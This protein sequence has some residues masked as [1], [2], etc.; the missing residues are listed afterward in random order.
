MQKSSKCPDKGQPA[1]PHPFF[2]KKNAGSLPLVLKID[3][4]Y[5]AAVQ[6]GLDLGCPRL[7]SWASLPPRHLQGG[8]GICLA[9]GCLPVR[10]ASFLMIDDL[11][12]QFYIC[13]R[14]LSGGLA[15]ARRACFCSSH[16]AQGDNWWPLEF[17]FHKIGQSSTRRPESQHTVYRRCR[18]RADWEVIYGGDSLVKPREAREGL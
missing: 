18:S 4:L 10:L 17:V 1:I 13:G 2:K 14:F 7:G 6:V 12:S 5:G 16:L 11:C 8:A 9:S 15:R 3:F